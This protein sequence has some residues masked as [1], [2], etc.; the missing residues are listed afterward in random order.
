METGDFGKNEVGRT[1]Q[2]A[3]ET[4]EVRDSHNSKGGTLDEMP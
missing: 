3:A 1:L 2:N 4:W